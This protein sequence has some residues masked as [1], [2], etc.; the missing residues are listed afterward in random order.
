MKRREALKFITI[1]GIASRVTNA[2]TT[3]HAAHAHY[4]TGSEDVASGPSA[5]YKPKYF[6]DRE[7]AVITR[8]SDLIIPHDETPG[9]VAAGVPEY[10]DRQTFEMPSMQVE[11]SG[12][13][14]WLDHYC[15]KEFGKDFVECTETQQKSVLDQVAHGKNVPAGMG[16]ARKLFVRVRDLTCE[17]FYSSKQGFEEVGYKGNTAVSVWRG[18]THPEHG[19]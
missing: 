5:S 13:I 8:L 12:G 16:P 2:Q 6:S 3:E 1:G 14:Q 7:Y 19:A 10:I 17:G 15:A 4:S 18:C 9:A 11:L